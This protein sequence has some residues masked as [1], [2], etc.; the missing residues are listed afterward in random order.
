MNDNLHN[1]LALKFFQTWFIF[2]YWTHKRYMVGW[3]KPLTFFEEGW[4]YRWCQRLLST[5]WLPTLFKIP[6]ETAS[7][8]NYVQMCEVGLFFFSCVFLQVKCMT[9]FVTHYPP[10]CELEHLY[11]QHVGN[12]HMAFLLNEPESTSDGVYGIINNSHYISFLSW[13]WAIYTL[14]FKILILPFLIM[15]HARLLTSSW[16]HLRKP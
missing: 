10:L 13:D 14:P 3:R 12:Y 2:C 5:V 6:S 11:P 1:L 9:L 15:S 4:R 8:L 7:P 16:C